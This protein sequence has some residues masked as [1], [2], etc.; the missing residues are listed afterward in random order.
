MLLW[1]GFE[2]CEVGLGVGMMETL[3]ESDTLLGEHLGLLFASR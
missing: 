3:P 2:D 1:V